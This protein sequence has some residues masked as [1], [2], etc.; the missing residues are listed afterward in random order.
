ML[1]GFVSRKKPSSLM[2]RRLL[3]F[4]VSLNC[5]LLAVA[6]DKP[7]WAR[8][9]IP[10][11]ECSGN[12]HGPG[13]PAPDANIVVE[14]RCHPSQRDD[15]PV[16]YLHV[17]T[18]SGNWHD[19]EVD[20]GAHEVLWSPDSRAFLVNGGTSAYAGFSATVYTLAD[21]AVQKLRVTEAAQT[22]MVRRF[23]PCKALNRDE[24]T[25]VEIAR[26]PE[27]NMSGLAW[28]R[29]SSAIIVMAEVPC[30]SSYGGI[31]CQV[32]GYELN[33]P[34]GTIVM[35]MTARQ[36]KA[37]WQRSMAWDMRIPEPPEYGAAQ[38][39]E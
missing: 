29:G 30:S 2:M 23:P 34:D 22:D 38:K 33:V 24:S 9:A 27:F 16:P 28:A 8:K 17:R 31:M 15:D 11:G 32:Q 3:L 14:L 39:S 6:A 37:Q 20:E 35:R 13:I 18:S 5:G 36:L 19:V 10:I 26:H 12:L 1:P 4:C 7:I 25:C 21:D